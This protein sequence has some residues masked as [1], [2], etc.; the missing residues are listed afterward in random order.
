LPDFKNRELLTIIPQ[1][2][3]VGVGGLTLGGGISHHT[4]KYGLACDNVASY[5]L[6]TA[7]GITLTVSQKTF[8][9]LYWAL[10]GGGNDFGIVTAFHYETLSQGLMFAT[11]R[12]YGKDD[13]PALFDAFD[14]AVKSAEKDTGLAHF[15]AIATYSGN[16]MANAEL[17][18]STPVN[19]ANPPEIIKQYLAVTPELDDTQN[20]TLADT[21]PPLSATIPPGFRTTM[22]D[23]S[24]KLNRELMQRMSNHFFTVAHDIPSISP[25]VTFQAFSKPAL[26]AMQ[27]KGG[28]ALGLYPENGPFFHVLFTL[29]WTDAKDDEANMKASQDYMKASNDMAKELGAYN[30]YTYMPYSSPYQ[31]VISGYGAK[32]VAKLNSVSKKYD[33]SRVF[34]KLQPG[35]FKLD[36]TA[37]Y[38]TVI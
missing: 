2:S 18:Y 26:V 28:N 23:Q 13:I 37:P 6:V 34:Q 8:P 14:T 5:E 27:K 20:M 29:T 36:G 17:E 1:A 38:G 12:Q 35:W 7:A 24:F 11:K 3:T 31:P 30:A 19:T 25:S 4:N 9:D 32:N 15:V 16:E 33:P 10:R 21:T 22:W